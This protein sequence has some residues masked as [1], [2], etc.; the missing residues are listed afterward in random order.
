M[1]YTVWQIYIRNIDFFPKI[2]K[3]SIYHRLKLQFY[4]LNRGEK[5]SKKFFLAVFMQSLCSISVMKLEF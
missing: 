1:I 3:F 5:G 4:L 2:S